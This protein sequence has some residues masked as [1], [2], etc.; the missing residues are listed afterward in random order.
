MTSSASPAVCS[1]K[2]SSV[3]PP[4]TVS[5]EQH[6]AC[7]LRQGR[8]K[9]MHGERPHVAARKPY[10]RRTST[11]GARCQYMHTM[12]VEIDHQARRRVARP[13]RTQGRQV[14][15]T[16]DAHQESDECDCR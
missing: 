10:H 2:W 8:M 4:R 14:I 1:R 12:A 15:Q 6:R 11:T 3:T 13:D 7:V 9:V 16:A 5:I